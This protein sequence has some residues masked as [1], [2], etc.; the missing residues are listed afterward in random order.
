MPKIVTML[1]FPSQSIIYMTLNKTHKGSKCSEK[2]QPQPWICSKWNGSKAIQ[3]ASKNICTSLERAVV[4]LP[5]PTLAK[6]VNFLFFETPRQCLK[7]IHPCSYQ[8]FWHF[9]CI[10]LLKSLIFRTICFKT[11]Q[12][13]VQHN[14]PELHVLN[15]KSL[16]STSTILATNQFHVHIEVYWIDFNNFEMI[17]SWLHWLQQR[18]IYF[19]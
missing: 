1:V 6:S 16:L 5:H 12:Q 19:R 18:I 17:V 8:N 4:V 10:S 11:V 13:I 3:I 9:A 2:V 7:S 15:L 14:N